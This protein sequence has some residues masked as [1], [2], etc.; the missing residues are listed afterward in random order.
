MGNVNR[1]LIKV[2]VHVTSPVAQWTH[3]PNILND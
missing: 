2:A 1:Y 3:F